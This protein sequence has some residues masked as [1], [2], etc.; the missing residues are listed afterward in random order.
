M[1]HFTI[2]DVLWLTVIAGVACISVLV[3]PDRDNVILLSLDNGA[4]LLVAGIVFAFGV[5]C[6]SAGKLTR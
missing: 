1:F 6:Y 3:L 5:V 2:R 4:K